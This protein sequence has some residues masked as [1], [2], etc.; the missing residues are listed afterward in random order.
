MV[1]G[2]ELLSFPVSSRQVHKL[3][4]RD[5]GPRHPALARETPQRQTDRRAHQQHGLV[6]YSG[7][8]ERSFSPG[9]QVRLCCSE[10]LLPPHVSQNKCSMKSRPHLT[11][12]QEHRAAVSRWPHTEETCTEEGLLRWSR[13][14]D[15]P[16]G[17]T[18]TSGRT[19]LWE[20][21]FPVD[22]PSSG[23]QGHRRSRPHGFAAG[24]SRKV[25]AR[26]SVSLLQLL[27][28]RS[29]MAPTEQWVSQL[30]AQLSTCCEQTSCAP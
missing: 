14:F 21:W 25:E 19:C 23:L 11:K 13:G 2:W 17:F 1:A 29:Q 20:T 9:G 5:P 6:P 8:A 27:P 18:V 7:S 30:H 26:V 15:Q 12:R 10:T 16:R 22:L 28:E 24:E 4:R 3:G